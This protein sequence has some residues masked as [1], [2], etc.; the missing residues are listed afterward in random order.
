V[1]P[2]TEMTDLAGF[3]ACLVQAKRLVGGGPT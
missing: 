1:A 2:G 3:T